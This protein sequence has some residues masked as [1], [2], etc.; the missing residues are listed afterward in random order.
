LRESNP[1]NSP[2]PPVRKILLASVHHVYAL[3]W[4]R[5]QGRL[6][7]ATNE[8]RQALALDPLSSLHGQSPANDY[9]IV[10]ER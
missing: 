10:K 5:P 6:E 1:A 7:E 3:W 2:S 4:L 8:N 9:S